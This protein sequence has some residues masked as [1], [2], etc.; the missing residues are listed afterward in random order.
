M[1]GYTETG[2]DRESARIR[3]RDFNP[4]LQLM[5]FPMRFLAGLFYFE[6]VDAYQ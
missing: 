2:D 6:S 1:T 4:T 5:H 3:G